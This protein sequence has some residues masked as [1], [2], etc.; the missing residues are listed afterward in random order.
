MVQL[1]SLVQIQE[2]VAPRE[3]NRFNQFRSATITATLA[4]GYALGEALD[5]LQS[6]AQQVLPDTARY[7]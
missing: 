1:T 5:L 3:L 4:P 2:N 6:A 7:D